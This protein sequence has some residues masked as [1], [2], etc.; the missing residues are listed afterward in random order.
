MVKHLMDLTGIA[1]LLIFAIVFLVLKLRKIDTLSSYVFAAFAC[2]VTF[3]IGDIISTITLYNYVDDLIDG[4]DEYAIS[5]EYIY[6]VD[7]IMEDISC[8]LSTGV[9]LKTAIDTYVKNPYT[10]DIHETVYT[11]DVKEKTVVLIADKYTVTTDSIYMDIEYTDSQY[12]FVIYPSLE[13]ENYSIP[14]KTYKKL[15]DLCKITREIAV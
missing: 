3:A 5:E 15:I 11:F 14:S 13:I 10:T 7:I 1:S 8:G 9:N 6:E 2:V 12:Y 4:T